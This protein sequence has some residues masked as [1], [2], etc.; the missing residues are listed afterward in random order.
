MQVAS[1]EI[2]C[3]LEFFN[4]KIDTVTLQHNVQ[5]VL[6]FNGLEWLG[7]VTPLLASPNPDQSMSKLRYS[8]NYDYCRYKAVG[9]YC[10]TL[11]R[12]E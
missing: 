2:I 10:A 11:F 8:K 9:L 5:I 1:K 12:L 7:G 6:D 3:V 4:F